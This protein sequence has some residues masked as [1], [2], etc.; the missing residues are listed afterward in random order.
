MRT[1]LGLF[2]SK[3]QL[4]PNSCVFCFVL[5]LIISSPSIDC[6]EESKIMGL[7][8]KKELKGDKYGAEKSK[9]GENIEILG[10]DPNVTKQKG[11]V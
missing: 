3:K 7:K 9:G 8:E 6:N 10:W 11:K 1:L 4:K 5:L 2:C